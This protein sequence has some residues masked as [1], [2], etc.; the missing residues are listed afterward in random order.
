MVWVVNGQISGQ[1]I[2][3]RERTSEDKVGSV[4]THWIHKSCNHNLVRQTNGP[5]VTEGQRRSLVWKTEAWL[6]NKGERWKTA[7]FLLLKGQTNSWDT[8]AT[9]YQFQWLLHNYLSLLEHCVSVSL[10][11]FFLV[12]LVSLSALLGHKRWVWLLIVPQSYCQKLEESFL[13]YKQR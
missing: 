12:R 10:F 4:I 8:L 6:N 1:S 5:S 3:G 7:L 9:N 11:C 13:T 2:S